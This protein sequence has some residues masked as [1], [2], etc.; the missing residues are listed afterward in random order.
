[1]YN[2]FLEQY[3]VFVKLKEKFDYNTIDLEIYQ[4]K[5]VIVDNTLNK[6]AIIEE[7]AKTLNIMQKLEK[8]IGRI[9]KHML[10]NQYVLQNNDI[11]IEYIIK[12]NGSD[13]KNIVYK[14]II[15]YKYNSKE[16]D[17]NKLMVNEDY[18]INFI[19]NFS[20]LLIELKVEM[21]QLLFKEKICYSFANPIKKCS[22]KSKD[23]K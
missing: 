5:D 22:M 12:S 2:V 8:T 3:K 10:N 13:Y 9:K 23:I 21:E 18:Y 7:M 15:N 19:N 6:N 20:K 17:I 14:Q 1:M 4:I 16:F 11:D